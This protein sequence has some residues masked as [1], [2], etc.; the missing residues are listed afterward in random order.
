MSCLQWIFPRWRRFSYA[1]KTEIAKICAAASALVALAAAQDLSPMAFGTKPP[2]LLVLGCVAGAPV[3]IGA[4]LFADAL[5]GLPFG[6]SA[7][8]FLG[9][10]LLVRFLKPFAFPA[11]ILSA[12]LYQIWMAMWGGDM[13]LRSAYAAAACAAVLYPMACRVLRSVKRNAGIET[14]RGKV[15]K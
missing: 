1:V 6:C 7:A 15:A 3:A 11:A 4:G 8:F 14:V 9:A 10:S 5:S 2:L 13:P 12:A